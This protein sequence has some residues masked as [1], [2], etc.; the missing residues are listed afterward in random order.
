MTKCKICI[1]IEPEKNSEALRGFLKLY[2]F[3]VY[4]FDTVR[5]SHEHERGGFITE[6][7]LYECVYNGKKPDT[8]FFKRLEKFEHLF[9]QLKIIME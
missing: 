4:I 2:D 7:S 5:N 6:N 9:K 1:F 8:L 3:R